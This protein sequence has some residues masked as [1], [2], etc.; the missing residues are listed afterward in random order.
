MIADGTDNRTVRDVEESVRLGDKM[1]EIV[2]TFLYLS[3]Y[4][5]LS[6]PKMTFISLK[7][8]RKIQTEVVCSCGLR[9]QCAVGASLTFKVQHLNYTRQ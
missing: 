1:C 5:P 9:E 7:E 4:L 6:H 3:G 8:L 2:E